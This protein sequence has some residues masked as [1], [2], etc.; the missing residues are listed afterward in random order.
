[1]GT[2]S[3]QY[4]YEILPTRVFRSGGSLLTYASPV[5]L[6]AGQI[7]TIPLGKSWCVGIVVRPT[8]QKPKFAVRPI[9]GTLYDLPLPSYLTKAIF[10]LSNYYLAPLP[11]V[12]AL[13][14]PSGIAT[15]R[16]GS[17]LRT[18]TKNQ[19][20][21]QS[22]SPTKASTSIIMPTRPSEPPLNPAQK[23]ALEGLEGHSHGTLLL[24]G[25]TGSGKTNIY[26]KMALNAFYGHQSSL[27]LV[28]EIALAPQLVQVFQNLFGKKHVL[29]VHSQLTP[30]E[31][32][33]LWE[34]ALARTAAGE[35]LV[36]IGPRSALFMPLNNLG[37]IVVD[38]AHEPAYYQE[39]NPRYSA[40]RLASFIARERKTRCVLGTATPSVVDFELAKQKQ[41][42]ISL[43]QKAKTTQTPAVKVIKLGTPDEFTRNRYFS[44]TLLAAIQTNL[45]QHHQT[46]IFHN[47]RGSAPITVCDHCGWQALCPHCFLPLT[48]HADQFEL[49]CHACGHHQPV[50]LACPN[51]GH[52]EILHKGFGTK[53]LE[54]ELRRLFP[55]AKIAR[56]DSDNLASESLAALFAEVKA[57]DFDILIGTQTLAR[58]L[59]LPNLAT[60]G[61]VQADAGLSLPDFAA[62]ERAFHLLTQVIGRVG[63]GHL[64]TATAIIQTYQPDHPVIQFAVRDDYL[65]FADYLLKTRRAQHFPPFFHLAELSV[66]YKTERTTLT[67]IHALHAALNQSLAALARQQ[68]YQF[69]VSPPLPAFHERTRRGYTWRLLAKSSARAPLTT[70]LAQLDPKLGARIVLDPPSLL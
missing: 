43:T 24:H 25:L 9:L 12:A 29:L 42:L 64:D 41:T 7:V 1:M 17:Q 2:K 21:K 31:R 65:G 28:P 6:A 16:R 46:L 67:K 33:L 19:P 37:L 49:R 48:L 50:P 45:E 34:D 23:M 13:A 10:W 59:D 69:E 55:E 63:R 61:V 18:R 5:R 60:V 11:E 27:I 40:V 58:G 30:A 56:F 51:C 70:A 68:P 3:R 8:Q 57:G 4:L 20:A 62:E 47:R 15:K 54:S 26:L 14:L 39:N 52:P 44:N 22:N 66:T 53:L 36:V 35:P 32:H 38:E